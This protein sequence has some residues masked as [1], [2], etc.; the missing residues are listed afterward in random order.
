M[1]G[2]YLKRQKINS[3][4]ELINYVLKVIIIQLLTASYLKGEIRPRSATQIL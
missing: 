2:V 3:N 4:N 1:T